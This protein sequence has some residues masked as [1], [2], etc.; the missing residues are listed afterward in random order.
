[1]RVFI[2]LQVPAPV[3]ALGGLVVIAHSEVCLCQICID[4]WITYDPEIRMF[5]GVDEELFVSL[6]SLLELVPS[7]MILHTLE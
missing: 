1:M 6:N 5:L 2:K 3:D 4:V 7:E